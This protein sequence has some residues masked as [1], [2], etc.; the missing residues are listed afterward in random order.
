MKLE[1]IALAEFRR[2]RQP[3][4]IDGLDDGL[5]VLVGENEA[6]KSTIAA[7]LRAAFLERFRTRSVADLAP[8]GAADARPSVE[9]RLRI[10]AHRYELRKSFLARARCELV[11]DDGAERLEG[12]AA[13]DRLAALLG[14]E[15]AGRGAS[16][17]QHAGVPGLLW[18]RQGE[19]QDLREPAGNAAAQLRDALVTLSGEFA[20]S[21]GDRLLA[22]VDL[23]RDELVDAR[24]GRPKGE[25][26]AAEDELAD[27]R[28]ALAA[29]QA[30]LAATDA[31][32]DRLAR[33]DDEY[34][35]AE[36]DAPWRMLDGQ[37]EAARARLAAIAGERDAAQAARREWEQA[38]RMLALLDEQVA[39]DRA[40]AAALAALQVQA[41]DARARVAQAARALEQAN[42]A[43][44]RAA[45]AADAARERTRRARAASERDERI[46][47]L[48]AL[49]REHERLTRAAAQAAQLDARLRAAAGVPAPPDAR[50]LASLRTLETELV[51]LRA[52]RAAIATRLRLCLAP[53]VRARLD[54]ELLPADAERLLASPAELVIDDVGTLAIA[55]GG[56]DLA[57]V[58][59]AL[60]AAE[61]RRAE[62][63]ARLGA[64]D[65]AS[66]EACAVAHDAAL[67]ELDAARR[68]LAIHAPDGVAALAAALEACTARITAV[69]ARLAS[70]ASDT[71]ALATGSKPPG[72]AGTP[73]ADS[74]AAAAG[75]ANELARASESQGEADTALADALAAAHTAQRTLDTERGRAQ[76]LDA[77]SAA[78]RAAHA[79]PAQ[80]TER[81]ARM[82]RL[83]ATRAS[84]DALA[85]R[86]RAAEAAIAAHRPELLEQD[87]ARFVRSAE[88]ARATQRARRDEI[89]Q[90]RGRLAQAGAQAAGE[91]R[92]ELAAR[93]ERLS[94]R[95]D[96]LA[97]RAEA[98]TLL[99]ERL[100]ARR[101]L[102]TQRLH[103]PLA[104]HLERYLAL[105]FPGAQLRVDDALRPEGLRR[106]D[107]EDAWQ[108]LSFGTREQL[109]ILIRF[110]Y[111]DLLREAGR[112][113]LIVLDDALVH[114]DA[115]RRAAMKRAIFD[116]ATR[117]QVLLLT[118]HPAA[119][120]DMGVALRA[121]D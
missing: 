10:G 15:F 105:L 84:H 16:Q 98:L 64:S 59:G 43:R 19:G 24:L 99:R 83:A 45:V 74:P 94:R 35:A 54:G 113:T 28:T 121:I 21:T 25:F 14:F 44:E 51:S 52:R 107:T 90:L 63:L 48:A 119:W 97:L 6:G 62:L 93:L 55:P 18:I 95:R 2:F 102:A 60:T 71:E 11:I 117:H 30:E 73:D 108:A 109:G 103:A 110:A 88:L 66:A 85:A 1:R 40:D 9:L 114:A 75:A 3:W 79:D 61:A 81:D 68:E 42:L 32:V 57:E 118:C 80:A 7:A 5:N 120:D 100:F 112:P 22:R 104:R 116:A 37:A 39:R 106:G 96:A 20:A 12:E 36:R 50:A 23:A 82:A 115:A 58:G 53:G 86:V 31:D 67:R 77:Q 38:G 26:K 41:D 46:A 49:G 91:R 111:A 65:L 17:P 13:E 78:R 34:A 33:L 89:Q 4:S 101:E 69:R 56:P 70:P 92:A 29:V 87:L 47:Q 27:A 72:T 76:A 8:W